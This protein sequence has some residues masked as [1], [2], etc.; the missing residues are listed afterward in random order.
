MGPVQPVGHQGVA[1]GP[2]WN[3]W[4]QT[5]GGPRPAAPACLLKGPRELCGLHLKQRGQVPCHPPT[6]EGYYDP[7]KDSL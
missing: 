4:A 2:R 3:V 6:P 1:S 5:L 7:E